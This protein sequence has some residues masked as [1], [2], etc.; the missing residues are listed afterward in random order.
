MWRKKSFFKKINISSRQWIHYFFAAEY[1][2][3]I[4]LNIR[5]IAVQNIKT[6]INL[7]LRKKLVDMCGVTGKRRT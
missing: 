6:D 1:P 7:F 4:Q 2:T 3:N 5:Q